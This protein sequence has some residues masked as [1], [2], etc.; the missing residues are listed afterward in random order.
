[1]A[2]LPSSYSI[3]TLMSLRREAVVYR[4]NRFIGNLKQHIVVVIATAFMALLPTLEAS[5]VNLVSVSVKPSTVVQGLP[6][7]GTV[8]LSAPAPSGGAVVSL[9]S[10]NPN[11]A[12]LPASVTIP[13]GATSVTFMM[14]TNAV[15]NTLQSP[16]PRRTKAS[17][18][19]RV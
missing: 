17:R 6:S 2:T 14:T 9:T 5:S 7:L 13:A 18:C 11:V 19:H 10:S 12:S 8:V 1:M 3:E 4:K 15:T 16:S